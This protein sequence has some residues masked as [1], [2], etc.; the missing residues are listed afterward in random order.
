MKFAKIILIALTIIASVSSRTYTRRTKSKISSTSGE[1]GANII[2]YEAVLSIKDDT[3]TEI[4]KIKIDQESFNT[5]TYGISFSMEQG[6][7]NNPAFF[8][9][10]ANTYQFNFKYANSFDC[11]NP[12]TIS[13]K[14]MFF[15][16]TID[17]K[18]YEVTFTFPNGWAFGSSVNLVSVCN[19]FSEKWT[20]TQVLRNHLQSQIMQLYGNIDL[21]E[22]T[23]AANINTIAQLQTQNQDLEG[24]VRATNSSILA[25][26]EQIQKISYEI[27]VFENLSLQEQ[28]KLKE[29]NQKMNE[30]VKQIQLDQQYIDTNKGKISGIKLITDAEINN[31]WDSY[32]LLCTKNLN[33]YSS[34]DPIK[35]KIQGLLGNVKANVLSIETAFNSNN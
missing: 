33:F 25:Q 32:K 29:Y 14:Q 8:L 6:L 16:V 3:N 30:Y 24:L 19:K 27:S 20:Q 28:D 9:T 23:K 2:N 22:Q 13:E 7:I 34:E 17:K 5:V 31:E 11:L 12:A 26:R 15:S 10:Q 35:S 1:V 18:V 4:H 21:L